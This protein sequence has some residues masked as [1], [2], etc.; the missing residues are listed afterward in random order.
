M[1]AREGLVSIGLEDWLWALAQGLLGILSG[2]TKSTEHPSTPTGSHLLG[3][4][5][6]S[7][8]QSKAACPFLTFASMRCEL[9]SLPCQSPGDSYLVLFWV[10][11]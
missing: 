10:V 4:L 7:D 6:V 9:N 3:A 8:L 1:E 5:G 11:Y 2:F